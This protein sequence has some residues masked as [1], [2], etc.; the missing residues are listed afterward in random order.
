[1]PTPQ[2]ELHVIMQVYYNTKVHPQKVK[3]PTPA[4]DENVLTKIDFWIQGG[5]SLED[6]VDRLRPHTIPSGYTF[7]T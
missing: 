2:S 6:I 7:N 5:T 4:V 3:T 1:M